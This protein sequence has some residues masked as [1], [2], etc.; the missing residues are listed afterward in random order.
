MVP[1]GGID[2]RIVVHVSLM[3]D[4]ETESA[5]SVAL[6][7]NWSAIDLGGPWWK[8]DQL[9]TRDPWDAN[10]PGPWG[11]GSFQIVA[12]LRLSRRR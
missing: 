11:P 5:I 8:A 2:E 10:E 6:F 4:Q 9:G 12:T 1:S 7:P 3:H